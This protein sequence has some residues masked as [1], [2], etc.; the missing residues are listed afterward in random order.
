MLTQPRCWAVWQA[1]IPLHRARAAVLPSCT[2]LPGSPELSVRERRGFRVHVND[3]EREK[4]NTDFNAWL[5]SVLY[6]RMTNLS[7]LRWHSI[8]LIIFRINTMLSFTFC[9][10]NNLWN[11]YI[12]I[13]DI[14]FKI[15]KNTL[16]KNTSLNETFKNTLLDLWNVTVLLYFIMQ[17]G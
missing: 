14:S 10:F 15:H 4:I 13:K 5:L 8:I 16:Y 12:I 11:F 3:R 2:H 6:E 9:R 1:P 17:K 7:L